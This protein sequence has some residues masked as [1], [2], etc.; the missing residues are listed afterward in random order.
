M[1]AAG[2]TSGVEIDYA[3]WKP[4]DDDKTCDMLRRG[5]T[6]GCFYLESP[7]V[8]LLLRKIWSHTAPPSTFALDIFEVLVQASSIIRPAA[9]SFI[10]E[11]LARMQGKPWTHLHPLLASVLEETLGIAIYQEQI[12]QI[13][14]E[15]AGF[16][17]VD[18]DQLRKVITK[19]HREKKLADYRELFFPVG[20]TEAS[21][22]RS[23]KG[24]GSRSSP[25]PA[26]PSVS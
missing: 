13:A 5:L 14:M 23:S 18:G 24:Y 12:T 9:N 6:I 21:R 22:K 26:I 3:T 20:P 1:A 4:Y 25:L 19:K 10:Q 17:A 7:S 16:S 11:Y 15:L 8:R 2:K